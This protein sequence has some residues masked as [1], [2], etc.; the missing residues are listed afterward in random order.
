MLS[1]WLRLG[2]AIVAVLSLGVA[3]PGRASGLDLA[4]AATFALAAVLSITSLIVAVSYGFSLIYARAPARA[5]GR[6]PDLARWQAC[7]A[8]MLEWLATLA[9]VFVIQPFER[10]WMGPEA[11]ERGDP[12]RPPLLLVHGYLCNRG[13]WWWLRRRLRAQGRCVATINLEPPLGSIERLAERLDARVRALVAETG[14]EK[15]VLVGH[16]MGGL[17]ARAYLRRHGGARVAK[18]ITLGTPHHGTQLA[19]IGLGRNAREMVPG[20]AW[21]RELA[22]AA[23]LPVPALSVWS[24]RDNYIMPQDSSRLAGARETM[25]PALGHLAMAFSPKI[26]Q[27]LLDETAAQRELARMA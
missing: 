13:F 20:S 12:E 3:L 6:A 23:P 7:R 17:A 15:I 11:K 5:P 10:R 8:A 4:A 9:L 27:I 16:S 14:A 22:E 25:L 26:L 24:A 2:L 19:R 18:L 1:N 21:I